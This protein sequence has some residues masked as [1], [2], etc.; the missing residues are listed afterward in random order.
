MLEKGLRG[1]R[2]T[3]QVLQTDGARAQ[4]QFFAFN[5]SDKPEAPPLTEWV[6]TSQLWPS[7]P[8]P[9][10]DFLASVRHGQPL[11]LLHEDGWWDVTLA[12]VAADGGERPYQVTSSQ[13]RSAMQ[14]GGDA[15]RP[16][17]SFRGLAIGRGNGAADAE[18]EE[19]QEKWEFSPLGAADG[20][21]VCV[22]SPRPPTRLEPTHRKS[23]FTAVLL[24]S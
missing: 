24:A 3:A 2:F 1:S 16:Q 6:K 18:Q 19:W 13:Y 5:E 23:A 10:P 9:P 17:W 21:P 7:P 15:L 14:V 12:S 8:P 20:A 22:D 11:S 4:V